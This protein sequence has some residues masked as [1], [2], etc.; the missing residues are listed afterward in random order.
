[1]LNYLKPSFLARQVKS[2]KLKLRKQMDGGD[3]FFEG[4]DG[5]FFHV[6]YTFYVTSLSE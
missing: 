3:D 4:K 2:K 5:V 6:C 1:M